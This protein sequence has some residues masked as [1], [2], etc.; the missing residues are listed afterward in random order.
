MWKM[1][2]RRRR[3]YQKVFEGQYAETVLADLKRF[4]HAETPTFERDD[5]HGRIQAYREGR[6][7][8]LLRIQSYLG[9]T[10]EQ[11][12]LMREREME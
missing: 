3:A 11:L 4:C 8:V 7:E 9:M 12:R 10:D 5:P 6:R 2:D 1:Y